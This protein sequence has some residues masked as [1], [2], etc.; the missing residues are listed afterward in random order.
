M[1][2]FEKVYYVKKVLKTNCK[3]IPTQIRDL[4]LNPVLSCLEENVLTIIQPL[5]RFTICTLIQLYH[6]YQV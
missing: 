6:V 1:Y 3:K 5:L 4:E 2:V